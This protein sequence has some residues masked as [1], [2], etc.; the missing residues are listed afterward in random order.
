MQDCSA[1]VILSPHGPVPTRSP[2]SKCHTMAVIQSRIIDSAWVLRGLD[3]ASVSDDQESESESTSRDSHRCCQ[4]SCVVI[5][6]VTYKRT[7]IPGGPCQ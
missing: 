4:V 6:I 2:A 7:L 5:R 1:A 3:R